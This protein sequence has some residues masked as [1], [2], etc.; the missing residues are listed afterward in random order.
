MTAMIVDVRAFELRIGDSF[1][2]SATGDTVTVLYIVRDN[3]F[4]DRFDDNQR[5]SLRVANH[6][7]TVY[8]IDNVE[9][10]EVFHV[11]Y[12]RVPLHWSKVN[13]GNLQRGMRVLLEN[14]V[15]FVDL[16]MGP[17]SNGYNY[18]YWTTDENAGIVSRLP[19]TPLLRAHI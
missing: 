4:L 17:M 19:K 13:A 5:F 8:M 2:D 16:V 7:G 14:E 11:E 6:A 3:P 10:F 18:I 15:V 9:P 1:V 12:A